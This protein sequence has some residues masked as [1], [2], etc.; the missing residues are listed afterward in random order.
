M[1]NGL[2]VNGD[3]IRLSNHSS[4]VKAKISHNFSLEQKSEILD[5]FFSRQIPYNP[6]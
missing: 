4:Q 6:S 5:R 2:F 1:S 3:R